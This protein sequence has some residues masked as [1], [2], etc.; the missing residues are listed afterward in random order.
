VALQVF[1]P[2]QEHGQADQHADA[3]GTE[4]VFPAVG[5]AEEA[6]DQRGEQ[7]AEVDAGV[8]QREAR[9]AAWVVVRVQLADDGG[10]VGLEEAHAHHDQR[11]RQ[12]GRAQRG[13]VAHHLAAD[14]LRGVALEGHAQVAE[15]QQD[16]AEHHRLAHAQ[17]AVG[18]QAAEHRH[19]V[20]Q[21]AVGAQQVQPGLVAE[22]VVLGQVQQQQRLHPVKG[23]ALPH[24]GEEADV[25]ALGVAEEVAGRGGGGCVHRGAGCGVGGKYRSRAED[26]PDG[27][28]PAHVL[29]RPPGGRG[30]RCRRG[31][32]PGCD[33]PHG[34]GRM[35]RY[36]WTCR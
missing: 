26:G 5:L 2:P 28:R 32:V 3:G 4:A 34:T 11:Q 17:P 23:E 9:I 24:F 21:P 19:A 8:E 22:Q 13:V 15:H 6:A 12:V 10:D 14:A 29:A 18:E 33:R 7:R 20:H 1:L 31:P 27:A 35:L 25:D 36:G 16:A 30:C